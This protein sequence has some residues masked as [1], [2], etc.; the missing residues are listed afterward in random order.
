MSAVD[1]P[2]GVCGII[3]CHRMAIA[4]RT[5]EDYGTRAVCGRHAAEEVVADV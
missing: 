2:D 5:F 4:T 3:G 1:I